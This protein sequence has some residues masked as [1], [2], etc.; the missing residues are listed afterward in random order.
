MEEAINA[1]MAELKGGGKE[2]VSTRA[3]VNNVYTSQ[4]HTIKGIIRKE[5]NSP[6]IMKVAE[7]RSFSK[8][9]FQLAEQIP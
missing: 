7:C 5:P 3:N 6:H 9:R 2:N 4:T 1:R 8:F